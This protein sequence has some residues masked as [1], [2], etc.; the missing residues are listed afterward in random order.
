MTLQDTGSQPTPLPSFKYDWTGNDIEGIHALAGIVYGYVSPSLDVVAR[1]NDSVNRL[2]QAA[3][4]QGQAA[5]AFR[6]TWE[7]DSVEATAFTDLMNSGGDIFDALALKL[8]WIQNSWEN[9]DPDPGKAYKM[10]LKTSQEQIKQAVDTAAQ[11]LNDLSASRVAAAARR[12]INDEIIP[13]SQQKTLENE[14]RV[15]LGLLP[16]PA[17]ASKP[18]PGIDTEILGSHTFQDLTGGGS[19]GLTVGGIIGGAAGM[20]GGPF[21][22]ITVPA[23]TLT[24]SG[25]GVVVGGTIGGIWGLGED[26]HIW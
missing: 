19:L 9:L 12:A 26:L 20:L 21:A 4:W 6:N 2:V 3:S 13:G 1:L 25:V 23:G 15:S 10:G 16:T 5:E 18:G 24:G 22:E 14:F 11:D 17:G 7:M 8:A